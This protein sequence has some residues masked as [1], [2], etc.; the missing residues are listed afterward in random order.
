MIKFNVKT[1][2]RSEFLDITQEVNNAMRQ[3]GVSDGICLVFVPH[4]TAAITLNE[5][6]DPSVKTDMVNILNKI[7]PYSRDYKHLEGNSD[8]HVKSSLVG[9]SLLL[10]V[11]GGRLQLGTWQGIQFC[12]F[13]GPRTRQVH[14]K[15]IASSPDV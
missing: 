11:E 8:A 4:T 5:N 12:E 2:S 13:D 1:H 3:S 9:P 6:A 14:L 10:A 15:I 7:S